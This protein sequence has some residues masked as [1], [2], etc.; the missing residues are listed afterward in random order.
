M[1]RQTID[2]VTGICSHPT[3]IIVRLGGIVIARVETEAVGRTQFGMVT[4][5]NAQAAT[6]TAIDWRTDTSVID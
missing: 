1:N 2:V 5:G 4:I 3:E 6:G